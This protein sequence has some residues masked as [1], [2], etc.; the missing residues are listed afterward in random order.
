MRRMLTAALA[1]LSLSSANAQ[2][3]VEPSGKVGIMTSASSFKPLLSV[4]THSFF[5]YTNANIGIAGCPQ[6][7]DV[8]NIGV[9]GVISTSS[10]YTSDKNFGVLG[11][12]NSMNNTHGRNYGASGM[13]GPVSSCYGGAGVYGTN[14]L[15]YYDIPTNIQGLY[16]GY[17]EGPVNV[18]GLLN[19]SSMY[20]LSDSRLSEH[21]E[22]MSQN[23]ESGKETLDNVLNMSVIEY[24]M[25]SRLG[26]N[27]IQSV[28]PDR[29]EDVQKAY[30][31][32]KEEDQKMTS[33]RHFGI[34]A[35]ELQKMYPDLVLEGQDGYLSVNYSEMVPLL[36]RSIQALKKELDEMKEEKA[37]S[38]NNT[39]T[40]SNMPEAIGRRNILFQNTPNPF[41]EKTTICFRLADDAQNAAVCIFDM[42]GKLLKK[43]PVSSGM[44]SVSINGYELGEGMFLYTLMANGRE[45]D[46]KRMVLSK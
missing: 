44:E 31:F 21:V 12:V 24:S 17:F 20:T 4:G 34:V 26:E 2:L 33:I 30:E 19:T 10:S 23:D 46:T 28:E 40:S 13:I 7:M 18:S 37:R 3:K 25:K 1:A 15:Y 39:P 6:T 11:I 43:I 22:R 41:K 27:E 16:A 5:T 35:E 36:I 42:S 32:L 45:V 14:S 9:E 8:N 29:E 38:K